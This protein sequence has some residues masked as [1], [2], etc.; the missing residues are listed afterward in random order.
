MLSTLRVG[1]RL[2]RFTLDLLIALDSPLS[3]LRVFSF[4]DGLAE[5]TGLVPAARAGGRL[6]D[7]RQVARTPSGFTGARTTAG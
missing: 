2:L 5:I 1:V 6:L 4:I 7:A 3:R